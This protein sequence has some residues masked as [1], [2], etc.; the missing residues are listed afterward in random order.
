VTKDNCTPE[1][2]NWI[3]HVSAFK[4]MHPGWGFHIKF[5][6]QAYFSILFSSI[7]SSLS[8]P[9]IKESFS[10]KKKNMGK[11]ISTYKDENFYIIRPS[12]L[13]HFQR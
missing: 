13:L 2:L 8:L 11:F 7:S 9:K 10:Q 6:P 12:G 1:N 5:W 4:I 3:L